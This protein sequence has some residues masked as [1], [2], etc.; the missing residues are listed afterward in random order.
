M[1][2]LGGLDGLGILAEATQI[3]S[4]NSDERPL[5]FDISLIVVHGIS[6]PPGVFGGDA[7]E[8][9]FANVLDF[10]AHPYYGSLRDLRVSAHFLVRRDGV[11]IQFVPCS[12]RA[13]HAGS[14]SWRRKQ[15]CNDFSI[16]VEIEGVD[17]RPYESVQY[18]QL[19][20]LTTLLRQR[21]PIVDIVGHADVS[22]GRKTDPGPA[23]DW[24]YFRALL[25][26]LH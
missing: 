9:L 19:G 3:H 15:N 10:S 26:R 4:P 22:P 1:S 11:L 5:G 8:R 12:M 6:L 18:Q 20:K 24:A 23:F 13:W 17:D 2:E 16:G 14:S 7:I 25:G 21:Y